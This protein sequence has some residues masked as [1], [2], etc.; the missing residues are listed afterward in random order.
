MR[1]VIYNRPLL[2]AQPVVLL[3]TAREGSGANDAG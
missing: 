2:I 1:A 3:N